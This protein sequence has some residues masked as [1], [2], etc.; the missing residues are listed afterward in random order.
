VLA[1][2]GRQLLQLRLDTGG[3]RSVQEMKGPVL[4]QPQLADLDGDGR[5]DVLLLHAGPKGTLLLVARS[6]ANGQPL[7]NRSVEA[8]WPQPDPLD[9]SPQLPMWPLIVDLDGDGKPEIVV[10]HRPGSEKPF[11]SGMRVLD[12]ATGTLRWQRRLKAEYAVGQPLPQLDQFIVGPDINGDGH[13]D[14]FVASFGMGFAENPEERV[15]TWWHLFV[16]ALSGANGQTLWWWKQPLRVFD[17][18]RVGPMRW[19]ESRPD[20]WPQLIVPYNTERHRE[21]PLREPST[22]FVL[23]AGTG[24]LVHWVS[25]VTRFEL[26]DLNGDGMPDLCYVDE[27]SKDHKLRAVRGLFPEIWSGPLDFK[28]YC[29]AG[30]ANGDGTSALV[31]GDDKGL[32]VVSSRDARV[33]LQSEVP[34]PRPGKDYRGSLLA[35]PLGDLDGDGKGDLLESF[36]DH[37]QAISSRDGR[38]LWTAGKT[39]QDGAS[40]LEVVAPGA[41]LHDLDGNG[42]PKILVEYDRTVGDPK[43]MTGT[44]KQRWVAAL[45]GRDGQVAWKIPL[46]T[47]FLGASFQVGDLDNDHKLKLVCLLLDG[48]SRWQ[49]TVLRGA[50]GH[51]L[52]RQALSR[53][54]TSGRWPRKA[55]FCPRVLQADLAGTGKK[56]VIVVSFVL[57]FR[58][59]GWDGVRSYYQV[60]AFDGHDGKKK[61]TWKGVEEG[62]RKVSDSEILRLTAQYPHWLTRGVIANLEGIGPAVCLDL[63][64]RGRGSH[65]VVLDARGRL[66]QQRE[67]GGFWP[68]FLALG[69]ALGTPRA[70]GLGVAA[71]WQTASTT[72]PTGGFS[73]WEKWKEGFLER[74]DLD[75]DGKDEL[76]WKTAGQLRVTRGGF[77]TPYWQW[78]VPGEEG[79]KILTLESGKKGT[80]TVV[81]LTKPSVF[82]LD[83]RTGKPLWRCPHDFVVPR[84]WPE[85]SPVWS[86][87]HGTA[88]CSLAQPTGPDGRLLPPRDLP[89]WHPQQEEDPRLLLPLPWADSAMYL[90]YFLSGVLSL[91]LLIIPG[92]LLYGTVRWRSW[93][94]G[95]LLVLDLGLILWAWTAKLI[96]DGVPWSQH[97]YADGLDKFFVWGFLGADLRILRAVAGLPIFLFPGLLVL[98]VV[99]RRW[100]LLAWLPLVALVCSLARVLLFFY[101]WGHLTTKD[102]EESFAW[103]GWYH[104]LIQGA[105]YETG[106]V[107]LLVLVFGKLSRMLR[108]RLRPNRAPAVGV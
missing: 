38:L 2:D 99:R 61:W 29:G 31:F 76:L 83:G 9:N 65:L 41:Q 77:L 25:H 49:L 59:T 40:A 52:W 73:S 13:K 7:W 104:A 8:I 14:L 47:H 97:Q 10:P 100:R 89:A 24:R 82:G 106:L 105:I 72:L 4:R 37:I 16:T 51:E 85:L 60:T 71:Y 84:L 54:P 75:G 35:R 96:P 39:L 79:C 3:I 103:G 108:R 22:L 33:L 74:A 34:G 70:V 15:Y 66:R 27:S 12:G 6:L 80:S 90:F 67:N 19:W 78:A 46:D 53:D 107:V 5:P 68:E 36:K 86:Y 94:L 87:A 32:R 58:N 98:W 64:Q 43:A 81:C 92:L 30:D 20:G 26:A 88:V 23:S 91:V 62:P 50:D 69:S 44:T 102:P 48:K 17:K 1:V 101:W 45:A 57:V 63:F 18:A 21:H 11:W 95:L 93:F 42:K 56:D 28:Q 55:H